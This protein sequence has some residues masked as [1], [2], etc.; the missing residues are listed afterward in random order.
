MSGRG[1]NMVSDHGNRMAAGGGGG[2]VVLGS[3]MQT[4]CG[5]FVVLVWR[6]DVMILFAVEVYVQIA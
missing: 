1:C 6:L 5:S 3:R 2:V 4:L